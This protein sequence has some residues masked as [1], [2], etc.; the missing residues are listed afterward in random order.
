MC[1]P[2]ADSG[3]HYIAALEPATYR[4]HP[5]HAGERVWAE[6][7]CYTDLAIELTHGLGYE[8]AAMLAFTLAI[9]FEG[10]QWTFFKPAPCDLYELY[11]FDL[12][13]L[14]IW[15]P[16]V[17]HVAE[18][19]QAGYPVLVEVDS[20]YLPDTTGTAYGLSHSKTTI[21]VNEIDVPAARLGYF[22]NA[23]YFALAGDDFRNLF[24]LEGPAHERVLPPYVE[25]IKW[26]R[27]FTPPR[28]SALVECSLALLRRHLGRVP[29]T[30]PF[31]RFAERFARDLDAL[32]KEDLA[33]FHAYS[34]ANLRQYGACFELAETYLRWLGEQAVAGLEAPAGALRA[35]AENAKALQFQ[36]ARAMS[37]GKPLDLA[38]VRVMADD[39]E[40]A[41][42]SLQARFA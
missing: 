15:R 27:D 4:R 8:P 2:S 14:A 16:L 26:R 9:D 23:G 3:R 38:P 1:W 36:L 6:T 24:Q 31:A 7:N 10:D 29:A 42:A 12:Q 18:Q 21:G 25:F 22:H 30:N 11:G 28:G 32:M 39:W 20:H 37:R 41:M 17:E 19:V 34:F 33:R 13:E 35:I 5:I 40:R